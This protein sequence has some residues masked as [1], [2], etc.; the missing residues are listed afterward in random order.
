MLRFACAGGELDCAE[1]N[2]TSCEA[3]PSFTAPPTV[4]SMSE[5]ANTRACSVPELGLPEQDTFDATSQL[6]ATIPGPKGKSA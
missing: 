3:E 5:S 1:A 6:R 4:A 2:E